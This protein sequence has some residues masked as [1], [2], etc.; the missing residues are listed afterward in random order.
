M[1]RIAIIYTT[2][3]REQLAERTV[4]SIIDNWC[5][6]FTLLIAD[7]RFQYK[8]SWWNEA[9]EM[10]HAEYAALP[11]DC[12]VSAARNFLVK[13]A[14]QRQIKYCLVTADSIE[15]VPETVQK[16]DRAEQFLKTHRQVGI[17]GFDL[18]DRVPWEFYMDIN[19][20]AFVLT[21]NPAMYTD[22]ATGLTIKECD[23][24]RQF[25]LAK[26]EA[27]LQVQW[28][29]A[30]K[31]ADHEDFFWRYKQAGYSVRWTADIVGNYID[32]K[33]AEYLKY[34]KRMY[35]EFR[36]ILQKKYNLTGWVEYRGGVG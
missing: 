32:Y 22:P 17:I 13:R 24:C 20:R 27:L 29:D 7:Q 18:K 35:S 15:F 11:F 1:S 31:T 36:K 19:D 34:R 26:T 4:K 28:D 30:L 8:H 9:V 12:G 23:I 33:P 3:L 16:I 25:F 6:N 14:W 21:K 5:D 2:F 10:R